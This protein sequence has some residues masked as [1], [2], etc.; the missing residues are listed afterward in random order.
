[1]R[2]ETE[3]STSCK[4]MV[5]FNVM[6][7]YRTII[8][9]RFR[10]N[11]VV[12]HFKH[13]Y[14]I[15]PLLFILVLATMLF[16]QLLVS[17]KYANLSKHVMHCLL[18]HLFS[19]ILESYYSSNV[20]RMNLIVIM[21]PDYQRLLPCTVLIDMKSI[22]LNVSKLY[23]SYIMLKFVRNN[24]Y[25]FYLLLRRRRKIMPSLKTTVTLPMTPS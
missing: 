4:F 3:N 15:V 17:T 18:F 11:Y 5:G 14:L 8:Q 9:I 19:K 6:M 21:R 7:L 16:L 20:E 22:Y 2:K 23:S 12:L 24:A 13:T 10:L 1:M 25:Q